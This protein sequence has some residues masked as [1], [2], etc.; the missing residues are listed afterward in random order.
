MAAV[1]VGVTVDLDIDASAESGTSFLTDEG[2]GR[3]QALVERS[4]KSLSALK[5]V[6]VHNRFA[7][8]VLTCVA[9]RVSNPYR[10][11]CTS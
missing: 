7:S 4:S 9:V 5:P 11:Q 2:G 8:A 3:A 1:Q 6:R 10:Q